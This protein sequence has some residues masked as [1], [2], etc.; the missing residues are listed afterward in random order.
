MCVVTSVTRDGRGAGYA[1]VRRRSSRSA[2]PSASIVAGRSVRSLP[3]ASPTGRRPVQHSVDGIEEGGIGERLGE[4]D[5]GAALARRPLGLRGIVGGDQDHGNRGNMPTGVA[6]H[7][8]T[9][10]PR[11]PQVGHDQIR[12]RP[13]DQRHGFG[14]GMSPKR[15][16][17]RTLEEARA[18]RNEIGLVVDDQ[19]GSSHAVAS[20]TKTK[21]SRCHGHPA[22]AL[23][24]RAPN[25]WQASG[26]PGARPPQR[27]RRASPSIGQAR[28][29]CPFSECADAGT[30]VA[31]S[32]ERPPSSRRREVTI[33]LVHDVMQTK[34]FTVTPETRLPEALR[35]TAQR[36]IRHLPVLDGDKLVGIVSD[37]DLKRAMPSSATSLEAHELT[38]LLDRLTVGEIMTRTVITIGAMFPIEAAARL[39]VQG[40][41]GA[42]PVTDGGRL[43]GLVTETDVLRLF[44]RAM[45]V[46][47]PS[48]RLD[49]VVGNRPHAL[50]E[51]VQTIEAA[52]A[53]ISSL[54]TLASEGGVKEI[55]VRVRTIN[56]KPVVWSLEAR[57]F[58]ARET[59]RG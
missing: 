9:V 25:D 55:V 15:D 59:W 47:E 23:G 29:N 40:T 20:L 38:Y 50:A 33:M 4:V 16:V 49:V 39:M 18:V 21:Q 52:G 1:S 12:F 43:V 24:N 30:R 41:I 17:S 2:P 46:S 53:E 3:S 57:G 6:C 35:L 44:V 32:S 54:V 14:P 42:L 13:V 51:V 5:V 56:P 26:R 22:Q 45:G 31:T 48:S 37:R 34:I 11:K 28:E 27:A 19:D 10:G 7:R 58:T 8:Q 36:G